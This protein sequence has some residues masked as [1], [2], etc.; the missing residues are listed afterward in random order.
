LKKKDLEKLLLGS[1]DTSILNLLNS[2]NSDFEIEVNTF[3]IDEN[4]P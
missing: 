2:L 3:E 1:K 4:L